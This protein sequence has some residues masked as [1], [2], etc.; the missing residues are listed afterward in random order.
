MVYL[1]QGEKLNSKEIEKVYKNIEEEV[2]KGQEESKRLIVMG[3]FNAKIGDKDTQKQQTSNK[4][5]SE[6]KTKM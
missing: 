1:P 6:R 5:N 3:D 2:R 4:E